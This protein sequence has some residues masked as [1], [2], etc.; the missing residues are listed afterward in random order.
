M[1][2]DVVI[3]VGKC[4]K[5]STLRTWPHPRLLCRIYATQINI[6]AVASSTV[7]QTFNQSVNQ[8]KTLFH[9]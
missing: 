2:P 4:E 6:V 1:V 8:T 9:E 5:W 3:T 7:H